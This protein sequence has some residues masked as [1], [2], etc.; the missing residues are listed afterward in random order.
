MSII[1]ASVRL[2]VRM[3]L[4][5]SLCVRAGYFGDVGYVID[6]KCVFRNP[7]VTQVTDLGHSGVDRGVLGV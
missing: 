6:I 7:K 5:A 3:C 1:G 4:Y 2:K